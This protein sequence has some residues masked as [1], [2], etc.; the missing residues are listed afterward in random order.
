MQDLTDDIVQFVHRHFDQRDILKV[1]RA[2]DLA[3]IT[4]PR[5]VRAVLYLAGG[6]IGMLN[7][8][9]ECATRNV[10]ELLVWAE[11]ETDVSPEP[12]WVRDMSL[13]FTHE[14]NLGMEDTSAIC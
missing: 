10:G 3:G 13:P 1:Y 4:T 14:R 9:V 11:C 6:R 8:Y 5:V 2:L 12:M 7:H